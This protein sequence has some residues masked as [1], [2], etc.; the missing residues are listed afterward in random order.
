LRPQAFGILMT[1]RNLGVLGG[2]LV[3][4]TA[5]DMFGSWDVAAPVCAALTVAA[6]LFALPLGLQLRALGAPATYGT[7][8]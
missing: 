3:L 4:A 6:L 7:R 8:R 5:L 1:G 2:P